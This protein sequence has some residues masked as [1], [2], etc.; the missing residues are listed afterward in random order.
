MILVIYLLSLFIISIFA[1]INFLLLII[2]NQSLLFLCNCIVLRQLHQEPPC[3]LFSTAS[4]I[5]SPTS[6]EQQITVE[7]N[8][9]II[10]SSILEQQFSF[11]A[12]LDEPHFS[13]VLIRWKNFFPQWDYLLHKPSCPLEY[14]LLAHRYAIFLCYMDVEKER[15][16][17]T[18]NRTNWEKQL[19]TKQGGDSAGEA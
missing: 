9:I 17:A 13:E 3:P 10:L 14:N 2:S 18:P 11:T 6:M 7:Q 8:P 15:R 16:V 4:S 5:H 12:C 19:N 1:I